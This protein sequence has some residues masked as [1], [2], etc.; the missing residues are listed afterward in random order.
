MLA[1]GHTSVSVSAGRDF[2]CQNGGPGGGGRRQPN[3]YF[4]DTVR[5]FQASCA[6]KKEKQIHASRGKRRI[7]GPG[8]SKLDAEAP[9]MHRSCLYALAGKGFLE[10]PGTS[11]AD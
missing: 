8:R 6:E 9:Q 1:F 2:S 5:S 11:D 10:E 4:Q 7:R 3:K